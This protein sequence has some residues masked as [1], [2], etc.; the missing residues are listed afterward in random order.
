MKK[1]VIPI[2]AMGNN[3]NTVSAAFTEL[4]ETFRRLGHPTTVIQITGQAALKAYIDAINQDNVAV[5]SNFFADMRISA[6]AHFRDLNLMEIFPFNMVLVIGDHPFTGFMW[7]R[8]VHLHSHTR[9]MVV[10][11]H[12]AAALKLINPNLSRFASI[13]ASITYHTVPPA[14]AF[15]ERP[16]DLLIPLS[17]TKGQS[18]AEIVE[19]YQAIPDLRRLAEAA[20][21]A[22]RHDHENY[23]LLVASALSRDLFKVDLT[24]MRD[25]NREFFWR[26]LGV[27]SD[28]DLAI[29][30]ERR[31][32][33]LLG[34]LKRVGPLR[35]AITSEPVAELDTDANITW[36]G[37]IDI[38]HVHDLY[39]QSRMVLHC[40][41]TYPNG[42]HERQ[43]NA[44]GNGAV[45]LSDAVPALKRAFTDGQDFLTVQ[46]GQTMADVQ[47]GRSM[48]Q[49]GD[50]AAAGQTLARQRFSLEAKAVQILKQLTADG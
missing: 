26:A 17:L 43:M 7:E 24:E 21:A 37:K 11:K 46:E 42:L 33:L 23:P 30:S 49:L 2:P 31:M 10:D 4:A 34:L 47:A 36:L 14:P 5:Y 45:L 3:N 38:T 1:I 32:A 39:R 9:I 6:G 16:I 41:P 18:M 29:R 28:V 44:M 15:A 12:F 19:K 40:H 20:Y 48:A 13:P 35:V 25:K 22:L 8:I 27:F 50:I